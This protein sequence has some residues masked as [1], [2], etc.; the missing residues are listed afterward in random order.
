MSIGIS[1][2]CLYPM[3][4]EKAL[5]ALGAAGVPAA[6]IFFNSPSEL[7]PPFLRELCGIRDSYG[8]RI[9][10][11]HPFSSFAEPYML[12]SGYLRRFHDTLELYK[13]Y[14]EAAA[15]LGAGVLSIHGDLR[16]GLL[17]AEE[18]CRRFMLIAGEAERQ[19]IVAAQEN[20]NG[21][22]SA[23]PDFLQEMRRLTGGAVRFTFDVK[24][25]VRA[26]YTPDEILE[27]MDGAVAH[28][29]LSDHSGERDCLLP[30]RG[31]Y[32]F[33][34]LFRRMEALD[35]RGAYIIEVY[36]DAFFQIDELIKGYETAKSCSI[37]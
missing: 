11:V 18:Y 35:Y 34:G 28:L 12:F 26:G 2:S 4:T 25:S 17:P 10:A 29:H 19:G 20:V 22:R 36:R 27:A 1:T 16:G 8:M 33:T 13:R 32:D 15:I 3:E 6:E 31:G 7:S 23:D 30:G 5:A 21:Y 24:Q 9:A 14:C 37:K